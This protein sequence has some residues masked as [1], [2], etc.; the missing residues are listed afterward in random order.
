MTSPLVSIKITA[1]NH[2]NFIKQAIDSCL[3]QET[4]FPYEIIIHDDASTDKTAEI[5]REYTE[6]FP[7]IIKPIYQT[8]NQYSKGVKIVRKF[9]LPQFT[10]KYVATCEGDDYWTDPLKLQKQVDFLEKNPEFSASAHQ[11]LIIN[12]DKQSL[13]N[14][15]AK[16]IIT[17]SDLFDTRLFHTA[18]FIYRRELNEI[19]NDFPDNIHS[20]D[21]LLFILIAA[22]GPIR[23]FN[24]VMCVYRQ[25]G[26]SISAHGN[27]DLITKDFSTVE[28]L[29]QKLDNFP[30]YR[31]LA[32]LHRISVLY[33]W[34]RLPSSIVIKHYVPFILYSFSYFPKNFPQ[35]IK[36]TL[37]L[38]M[39]QLFYDY[40]NKIRVE[41]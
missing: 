35:I 27:Y 34:E 41:R 24:D 37:R 5:I 32:F 17:L 18:S 29:E 7:Q 12:K 4:D 40:Y 31:Y 26:D 30:K 6:R 19:Y 13:F 38:I 9:M 14:K 39:K 2:E 3:M 22:N 25:H 21:R 33:P 11:S 8:E 16:E 23:F 36:T 28:Y 1:Y 20:G 15:K 10:G